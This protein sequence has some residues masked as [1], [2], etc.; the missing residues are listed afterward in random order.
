MKMDFTGVQAWDP[1][2]GG[3]IE[4][5]V[6]TAKVNKVDPTYNGGKSTA[7]EVE[8]TGPKGAGQVTTLFIGNEPGAKGG[9]LKK[10]K[11]ALVSTATAGGK[12]EDDV[13]KMLA[14]SLEFDPIP[15]FTGKPVFILVVANPGTYKDPTTGAEKANGPD[16]EFMTKSQYE[17]ALAAEKAGHGPSNGATGAT[18]PAAAAAAAAPQGDVL[19]GLFG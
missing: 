7:F 5:G 12:N 8:T 14:G 6:Y 17:S 13:N 10:W 16:R 18:A 1:L 2:R 11:A 3:M 9:N 4:P 15:T 19:K